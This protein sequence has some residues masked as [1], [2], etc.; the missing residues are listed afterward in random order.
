M[1]ALYQR[2]A[3][4]MILRSALLKNNVTVKSCHR[5]G[6]QSEHQQN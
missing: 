6:D 2:R 3:K 5:G 4:L 1:G